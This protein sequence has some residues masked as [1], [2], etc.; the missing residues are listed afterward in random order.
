MILP[1]WPMLA[2]DLPDEE[3]EVFLKSPEWGMEH[4]RDGKRML[5]RLTSVLKPPEAFSRTRKGLAMPEVIRDAL[6]ASKCL[7]LV[8][9]KDFFLDGEL[10]WLDKNGRDHRTQVQAGGKSA[11]PVYA[12]WDIVLPKISYVK[13]KALLMEL[14]KVNGWYGNAC[15]QYQSLYVT[16]ES[17]KKIFKKGKKDRW[18]G[19]V[20]KELAGKYIPGA[21]DFRRWKYTVTDDYIV[22]GFTKS[23]KAKNPFRALVLA[24]YDKKGNLVRKG[25]CGGGFPDKKDKTTKMTRTE[26]YEKFLKGKKCWLTSKEGVISAPPWQP[27]QAA[28]DFTDK[29]YGKTYKTINWLTKKDWFVIEVKSQGLTEYF[30]PYMAQNQGIRDNDDKLPKDCIASETT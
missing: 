11:K 17:K 26:I 28:H 4:K 29:D 10:V 20:F 23:D 2:Y 30:I 25:Q 9:K 21:R 19:Y 18:E 6:M 16:E 7:S 5:V 24:Q 15:V 22:V 14:C 27:L 12:V 13:R 8:S 3:L 1:P